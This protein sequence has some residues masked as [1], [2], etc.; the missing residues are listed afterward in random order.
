MGAQIVKVCS[1]GL[2][3]QHLGK[4]IAELHPLFHKLKD[5]FGFN[6]CGEGG[7]YESAV[8]DCPLFKTKKIVCNSS[9]VV[10]HEDNSVSSVAY[11]KLNDLVLVDKSP[12]RIQQD[13]LILERLAALHGDTSDLPLEIL[14]R[15]EEQEQA[16]GI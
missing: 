16:A 8:F 6:V 3:P 10:M 12:E 5:Q 2:E 9:E 1:M 4:T 14:A 15:L 11:L 7:E 13:A